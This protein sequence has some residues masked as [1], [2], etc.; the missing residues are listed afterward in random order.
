MTYTTQRSFDSN[1]P[2]SK[3]KQLAREDYMQR[4]ARATS[5]ANAY[6]KQQKIASKKSQ[7][8]IDNALSVLA[9]G[10]VNPEDVLFYVAA[11]EGMSLDEY[12]SQKDHE[13]NLELAKKQR[14]YSAKAFREVTAQFS[15]AEQELID[16]YSKPAIKKGKK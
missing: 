3:R 10:N 8:E 16:K 6:N 7:D 13:F 11:S 2:P 9:E 15:D 4:Q 5:Q 1:L 12:N 14:E